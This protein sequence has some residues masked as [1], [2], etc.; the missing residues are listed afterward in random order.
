MSRTARMVSALGIAQIVSWGSLFYAIGVLGAPMRRELGTSDVFLFGAFTAGLL[1]S[2]AAAPWV[3]RRV[4]RDGGRGVLCA[5]SVLAAAAMAVLAASTSP[6]MMVAGWL[7]AGAAMAGTLYD[8]AFATLSYHVGEGYRRAVTVL[9]L[10]GGFASTVFWPLSQVLL[11][12]VGWRWTFGIYALLHLALTLPIHAIVVPRGQGIA[13]AAAVEAKQATALVPDA[14]L[15]TLAAAFALATFVQGIVAVHLIPLL[16]EAGLTP[17]QA[18][19]I[20]MLVGPMQVVARIAELAFARRVLPVHIGAVAF[21]LVAISACALMAVSGAGAM[22]LFFVA[23]FGAGNGLLTIARGTVPPELYG[24]AGL[25]AL[26][27]YVARAGMVARAVAPA[28]WPTLLALGLARTPALASLAG[29]SAGA[30]GAYAWAVR[31]RLSR[32]RVIVL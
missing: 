13:R 14:S 3:G 29:L 8:P 5:G 10:F 17:A 16:T 27:G 7:L 9:T 12:S 21:A 11:D 2:G 30:L 25:G 32:P 15:R 24:R 23:A 28:A 18:V 31:R 4:D 1:V 22:S 6:W 19:T 26:L 20:S